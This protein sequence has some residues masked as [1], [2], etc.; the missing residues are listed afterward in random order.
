[1]EIRKGKKSVSDR[2][3]FRRGGGINHKRYDH[4]LR[5]R[6]IHVV[7]PDCNK[8]AIAI[9]T[10]APKKE[11]VSDMH[12]SFKGK[13]FETKCTYCK[14]NEKEL[15]YSELPDPYHCI[16]AEGHKLW[17]YNWKHLDLIFR[18]LTNQNIDTHVYAFYST[19]IHGEW[20]KRK[21]AFSTAIQH[22]ITKSD[23]LH[24]FASQYHQSK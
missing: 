24:E 2:Y 20:K 6:E 11:F 22:H 21:K 17:A 15:S 19:Y 16:H 3:G 10:E 13:P 23:K 9:D 12:P 7:C 8:M 4:I 5:P 14:Y 1:M 18:V